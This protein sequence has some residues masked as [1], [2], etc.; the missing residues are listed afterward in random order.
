LEVAEKKAKVDQAAHRLVQLQ[1]TNI[2]PEDA[3]SITQKEAISRTA[4]LQP[5]AHL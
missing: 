2:L 5:G 3:H 1:P 4:T